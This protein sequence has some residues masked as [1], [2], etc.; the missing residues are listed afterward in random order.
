MKEAVKFVNKGELIIYD[1]GYFDT[2]CMM[3]IA[4][5]GSYFLNR[6][7]HRAGLYEKKEDGTFE[8]FDLEKVLKKASKRGQT[9]C[10]F[11]VWLCKDGRELE[12]RLIAERVPDEVA[13][14][15]RRKAKKT[16]K[17]KGRNPT[18]KHLYMQNWSLYVTNADEDKLPTKA[19]SVVYKLRWYIEIVF[20]SWK[21]YHGLDRVR[22]EREERIECFIYGRLI[23]MVIMTFLSGSI[24]RHVWHTKRREASLLKVIGHFQDKAKKALCVITDLEAFSEFLYTEFF[25]ACRLC[26]M[27]SRKRLSTA[28]KVRLANA[29]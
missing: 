4:D 5:K 24:K 13:N 27:D 3:D 11:K 28:Q 15:R 1:L 9:R 12:V 23:M 26:L 8:K 22:G 16:A 2:N 19:I 7:N 14:T 21:S 20:K 6:F 18:K 25:E 10:E 29:S 17:K